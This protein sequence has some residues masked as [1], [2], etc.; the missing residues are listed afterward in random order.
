MDVAQIIRLRG[1]I[2]HASKV[3]KHKLE[4]NEGTTL[5]LINLMWNRDIFS[6]LADTFQIEESGFK[7]E[8]NL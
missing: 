7:D 6:R 1:S 3:L 8:P 2:V 4:G 5:N